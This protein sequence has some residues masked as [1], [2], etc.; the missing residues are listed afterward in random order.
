MNGDSKDPKRRRRIETGALAA[1]GTGIHAI[2]GVCLS[3]RTQP[4]G[5]AMLSTHCFYPFLKPLA[6]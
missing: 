4:E 6:I 5:L 1:L 3:L 2:E